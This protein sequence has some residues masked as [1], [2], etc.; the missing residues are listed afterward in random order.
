MRSKIAVMFITFLVMIAITPFIFGKLMNAK[1]NKMLQNLQKQ[2]YKIKEINNKST[3]LKTDRVFE[4]IV[5]LKDSAVKCAVFKIESVFKNLPV[6]DVKFYGELKALHFVQKELNSINHYLEKKIKFLVITPNFKTYKYTVFDNSIDIQNNRLSFKGIE[7]VVFYPKKGSLN[8]KDLMLKD[9]ISGYLIEIKNLQNKF[10]KDKGIAQNLSFNVFMKLGGD[11]HLNGAEIDSYTLFDKTLN[12]DTKAKFKTL[13]IYNQV[14]F[15]GFKSELIVNNL[16][17]KALQ[18]DPKIALQKG[19]EAKFDMSVKKI[20]VSKTDIGFLDL[21]AKVKILPSK[22]IDKLIKENNLSFMD[23]SLK[24]KTSKQIAAAVS[25]SDDFLA[26]LLSFADVKDDKVYLDLRFKN[27]KLE[28][29][30]KKIDN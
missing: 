15:S 14:V 6:T 12:M 16:D 3:Y 20:T 9:K 2:G 18:K 27:S 23:L 1:F 29:N 8:I 25:M 30:G 26:R 21:S 4:V 13:N 7:G 22:N 24:L 10:E 5:P 11:I 17:Y 19:Y 28:I